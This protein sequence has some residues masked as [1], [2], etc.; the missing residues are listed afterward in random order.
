M[1]RAADNDPIL[2]VHHKAERF[3]SRLVRRLSLMRVI[4]IVYPRMHLGH[5]EET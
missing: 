1:S 4:V 5:I 2:L 3:T